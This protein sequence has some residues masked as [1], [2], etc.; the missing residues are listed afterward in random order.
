[1]YD[2]QVITMQAS[3]NYIHVRDSQFCSV[4]NPNLLGFS[5]PSS[6][7]LPACAPLLSPP[8]TEPPA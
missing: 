2:P 8:R 1:M 5:K 3:L 7:Q 4:L 6:G